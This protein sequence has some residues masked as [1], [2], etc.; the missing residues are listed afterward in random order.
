MPAVK[1]QPIDT[2]KTNPAEFLSGGAPASAVVPAG[3]RET[4]PSQVPAPERNEE[5]PP[6]SEPTP[7]ATPPAAVATAPAAPAQNPEPFTLLY[8]WDTATQKRS[9]RAMTVPGGCIV[10]FSAINGPILTE[11]GCFVPNV[12][13]VNRPDGS[14]D[15]QAMP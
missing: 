1:T 6:A 4:A 5:G 2:S 10:R 7:A 15:L 14:P 8:T 11:W 9:M 13:I 12:R 3:K